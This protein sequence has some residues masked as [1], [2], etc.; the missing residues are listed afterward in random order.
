MNR[1]DVAVMIATALDLSSTANTKYEDLGSAIAPSRAQGLREAGIMT[2]T[3][4]YRFS[5]NAT[6]SK[7]EAAIIIAN[8]YRYL[9][10][11]LSKAY[12][13]LNSSFTD[14]SNLTLDARQSIAI[15]ELFGVVEGSGAFNPTQKLSR[16]Q[17]AELIYKS[18]K[19]ID[20]L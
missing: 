2:G 8:M 4:S 7:Q 15:L 1:G 14:I 3:T 16:G 12:N 17:F 11:D 9:N 18:L 13:E 10:Q 20:F 5:P 19:A 6:V